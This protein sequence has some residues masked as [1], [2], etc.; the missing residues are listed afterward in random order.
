MYPE[1][2]MEHL[3]ILLILTSTII[4]RVPAKS[5]RE[6]HSPAQGSALIQGCLRL[7]SHTA[8]A[9]ATD[10]QVVR[11]KVC[12]TAG[13]A[14]LSSRIPFGKLI[15]HRVPIRNQ[16]STNFSHSFRQLPELVSYSEARNGPSVIPS[17]QHGNNFKT[18]IG[19]QRP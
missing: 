17:L 3:G 9:L 5:G 11:I 1:A 19:F 12:L 8:R 7:S 13:M 18:A 4:A 6:D 10:S 16:A 15:G 2:L 14:A